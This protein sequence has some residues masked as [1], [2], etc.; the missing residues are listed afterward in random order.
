MSY[1]LCGSTMNGSTELMTTLEAEVD[2]GLLPYFIELRFKLQSPEE[3][4][5]WCAMR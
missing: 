4:W 2:T 3:A 5:A 1:S